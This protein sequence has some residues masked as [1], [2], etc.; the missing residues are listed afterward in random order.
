MPA[1]PTTAHTVIQAITDTRITTGGL[2]SASVIG[3]VGVA[4]II[5]T[6]VITVTAAMDIE[7]ATAVM[8]IG[9]ATA[10][11]EART[12]TADIRLGAGAEDLVAAHAAV[13]VTAAVAVTAK[14]TH[15]FGAIPRAFIFR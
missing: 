4:A 8:G 5:R 13:V 9:A 10:M 2:V 7:A 12:A 11:R 14:Q 6:A 1:I 15:S 3:A